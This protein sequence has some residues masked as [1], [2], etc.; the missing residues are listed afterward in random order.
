MKSYEGHSINKRKFF[1]K[2]KQINFLFS[3]VFFPY[4]YGALENV[5]YPFI[6]IAPR[7]TL[8]WSGSTW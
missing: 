3:S 7:S 8:T 2:K 6:G 4:I 5:E 1:E